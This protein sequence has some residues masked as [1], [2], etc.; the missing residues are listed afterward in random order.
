MRPSYNLF[1]LAVIQS[2]YLPQS[3]SKYKEFFMLLPMVAPGLH[4]LLAVYY[5]QK[6]SC[7]AQVRAPISMMNSWKSTSESLFKSR[8]FRN[9]STSS[10]F[11]APCTSG[12]A[13]KNFTGRF[14]SFNKCL[15]LFFIYIVLKVDR[16]Y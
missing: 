12:K 16:Q 6:W 8:F 5:L 11:F 10:G 4:G 9:L 3:N 15:Y 14:M 1:V 7:N 2:L 13:N